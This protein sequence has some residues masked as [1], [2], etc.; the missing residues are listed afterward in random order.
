MFTLTLI[1]MLVILAQSDYGGCCDCHRSAPPTP[2]GEPLST[3]RSRPSSRRLSR[4]R[5]SARSVADA[6]TRAVVTLVALV[7]VALFAVLGRSAQSETAFPALSARS[8]LPA[9]AANSKIAYIAEPRL[10]V[11]ERR[12]LRHERR[13]ERKAEA[14]ARRR[15]IALPWSPDGRKIAFDARRRSVNADGSGQQRLHDRRLSRM[16]ARRAA[17][18]LP[19]GGGPPTSAVGV[20]VMNADGTSSATGARGRLLD[21]R[22]SPDGRTIAF[23]PPRYL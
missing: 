2:P 6:E 15:A 5:G 20:Y 19:H 18:R 23:V 22:W 12:A 17:D 10:A 16:V 9:G 1:M 3:R 21:P 13:R 4:K 14:D 8:S 11:K 7:G